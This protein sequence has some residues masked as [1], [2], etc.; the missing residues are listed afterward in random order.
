MNSNCQNVLSIDCYLF[1]VFDGLRYLLVPRMLTVWT[2]LLAVQVAV[3]D[4]LQD[5]GERS[6]SDSGGNQHRMFRPED[7]T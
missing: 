1:E 2:I 4:G 5:G 3:H 6:D 7:L